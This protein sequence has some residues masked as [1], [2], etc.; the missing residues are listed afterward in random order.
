MPVEDLN[1]LKQGM[2]APGGTIK[3]IVNLQE[4]EAVNIPLGAAESREKAGNHPPSTPEEASEFHFPTIL[5]RNSSPVFAKMLDGPWKES[6]DEAVTI[7]SFQPDQFRIF[8]DCL[9][10]LSNDTARPGDQLIFTASVIRKVLPVA[11]YFQVDILKQQIV[12]A[13]MKKM[14]E[15]Q[16]SK[17]TEPRFV[18]AADSLFA[19]E[20]NLPESEIPDWPE[21]TLQQVLLLM[22]RFSVIDN[23]GEVS[24]R[25]GRGSSLVPSTYLV[26]DFEATT[27]IKYKPNNGINDL[28]KKTLKKCFQSLS[29]QVKQSLPGFEKSIGIP[30]QDVAW[31]KLSSEF[32]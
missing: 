15:C 14:K 16:D 28:S 7:S 19:V 10:L 21:A 17:V 13:V 4:P 2:Y 8:L 25:Y 22:L 31:P 1:L 20:A 27:T 30:V 29:L 26:K 12:S 6:E 11:H 32:L 24:V 5:L 9:L 3:I 23:G 18:T